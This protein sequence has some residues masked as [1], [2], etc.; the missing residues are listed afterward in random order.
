MLSIGKSPAFVPRLFLLVLV[1]WCGSL[2]AVGY[3]VAPTLFA[4]LDRATA[5]S[6]AGALFRSEAMLCLFCGALSLS[7]CN[8]QLRPRPGADAASSLVWRKL[9]YWVFGMLACIA[10][11]FF[12]VMPWMNSLREQAAQS[13]LALA[14]APQAR[15]FGILHGVSS[16]LYLVQSLL[17][18]GLLWQFAKTFIALPAPVTATGEN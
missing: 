7:L 10:I 4:T 1:V 3:L 8:W 9:R 18:L 15:V 12:F 17:G 13:G 5:G 2:W 14:Q 11:G 16:V 6:V